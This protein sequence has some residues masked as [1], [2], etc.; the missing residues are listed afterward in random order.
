MLSC[1]TLKTVARSAIALAATFS[2]LPAVAAIPDYDSIFIFGD[3]LSDPG[4]FYNSTGSQFPPQP[5]Y[6]EG[7]ASNGPVW[8]EYLADDLGLN[9]TTFAT[10]PP[11][12]SIPA[13]GINFSF[14]GAT[15]GSENIASG[16]PG[17]ETQVDTYI[18]LL[19]GQR[20][21]EDG[22]YLL[23][24]GA[25]D[26]LGG[27][28]TNPQETA[29]NLSE[30]ITK[31]AN[32][33]ARDI[34]VFNLP[35]LGDSPIGRSQGS[36]GL[37][38][39]TQSHNALLAQNLAQLSQAFPQTNI[40]SFD[41]NTLVN[42]VIANPAAF[43][44]GNVTDNCTGIE[45]PTVEANDTPGWIACSEA[46][47]SDPRAFLFYDNQ[48]PTTATH[49]LIADRV[50]QRLTVPEPSAIAALGLF[51]LGV[52]VGIKPKGSRL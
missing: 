19:N 47:A 48:H 1:F 34:V 18:N 20:A 3:S 26:F 46:L 43:G 49:R 5:F 32:A 2:T 9:P 31:L 22:L 6:F 14:I 40:I 30:S 21:D 41:V 36:E 24:G 8:A 23:W 39:L 29:S 15:T 42:Q 27:F 16:F 33:G 50:R 11:N 44:Y 38:Q 4:N 51:S 45:F 12:S 10:L 7:R 25:N 37:N 28:P 17:I 13:D 35:D 52:L